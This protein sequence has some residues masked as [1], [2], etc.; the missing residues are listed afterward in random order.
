MSDQEPEPDDAEE[1]E[2]EEDDYEEEVDG[3]AHK[4]LFVSFYAMHLFTKTIDTFRFYSQTMN[5]TTTMTV[6]NGLDFCF[7][8]FA[9]VG[10]HNW[11]LLF[12]CLII[13]DEDDDDDGERFDGFSTMIL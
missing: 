8:G 10:S 4:N 3:K 2:E 7:V 6:S 12:L 11:L 5:K 13:E 9:I 1:E